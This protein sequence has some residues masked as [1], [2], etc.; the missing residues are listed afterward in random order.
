MIIDGRSQQKP[1]A[2]DDPGWIRQNGQKVVKKLMGII[3]IDPVD[4]NVTL[5]VKSEDPYL[6]YAGKIIRKI[7][8]SLIKRSC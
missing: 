6:P 2:K 8:N 3:T 4:E 1:N 7:I 5:N